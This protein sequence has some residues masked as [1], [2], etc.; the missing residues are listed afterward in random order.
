MIYGPTGERLDEPIVGMRLADFMANTS[1]SRSTLHGKTDSKAAD[2]AQQRTDMPMIED[3]TRRCARTS[4]TWGG[5]SVT[6]CAPRR[7]RAVFERIE[8]IR[9]SSIRF[10]RDDDLEA[11]ASLRRRSMRS[12]ATRPRT[13]C[14]PSATS[15]TWPTSPRTS[16][17]TRR[18]RAHLI[19]GSAP[20]PG[21]LAHA[22]GRAFEAG[23]EAPALAEF[24][25]SAQVSPVLT[26]HP[27]EV[28]RKSILNCQM[29]IA[30]LLDARDRIALTPEERPTTRRRC[31]A[32]C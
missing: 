14:A 11:R 7:A 9:Q 32:A 10:R 12:R 26:A 18:S 4:A 29:A 13:W 16:T 19:A 30:R 6:R 24:F 17:H 8:H 23:L 28:S 2:A 1:C 22:I 3:R 27:T 20:R 21:S 5:F 25:A 15:R 31:A